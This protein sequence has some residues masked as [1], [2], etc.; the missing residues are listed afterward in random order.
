MTLDLILRLNQ[1]MGPI[2]GGILT[3]VW[4]WRSIFW[5]LA[6]ICGTTLVSFVLFF[7]DTFRSE[8]SLTYQR[9]LKQ[10]QR[11]TASFPLSYTNRSAIFTR[12]SSVQT[13]K[14]NA[15]IEKAPARSGTQGS[16]ELTDAPVITLSLRDVN[17]FH[18]IVHVLRRPNNFLILMSSGMGILFKISGHSL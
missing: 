7:Q 6:I 1:A 12:N 16:M 14:I 3:T 2:F 9:Q 4:G 5:F 15:D 13:L 17:P 8:R 18:P 10:R 11:S